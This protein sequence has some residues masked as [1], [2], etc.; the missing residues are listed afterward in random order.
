M[1]RRNRQREV[2]RTREKFRGRRPRK[3]SRIFV[4][5]KIRNFRGEESAGKSARPPPRKGHVPVGHVGADFLK[6]P[7]LGLGAGFIE[8]REPALRKMYTDKCTCTCKDREIIKIL[9]KK[10]LHHD[11]KMDK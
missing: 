5:K 1:Y 6:R 10:T 2:L 8:E 11:L 4:F 7:A 9:I 3:R